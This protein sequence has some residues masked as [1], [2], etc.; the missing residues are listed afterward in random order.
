[1]VTLPIAFMLTVGYARAMSMTKEEL[2]QR[3]EK[4]GLSREELAQ[5]L[6][7]TAV[8]VWRWENGERAIPGHLEL[9]LETV[10]RN[11]KGKTPKN[12]PKRSKMEKQPV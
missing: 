3:R 6:F 1:M 7:T 5:A 2:Q 11:A 8:T 12:T 9:A 4:L 10:E